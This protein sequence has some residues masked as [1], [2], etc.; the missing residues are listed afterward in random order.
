MGPARVTYAGPIELLFL[1]TGNICRS[2]MG[3]AILAERLSRR[4]VDASVGSAGLVLQGDPADP[5]AVD[6]LGRMGIDL[7]DHR[8]RIGTSEVV[9]GADLRIA[10]ENRHVRSA[11]ASGARFDRTFTLPDLVRRAEA[12]GPRRPGESLDAWLD[13]LGEGRT[14]TSVMRAN[15]ADEVVDP[16]GGSRRTFRR[17]AD[18]LAD[19]I[20]RLV[21]L[22]WP[23]SATDRLEPTA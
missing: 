13:R 9:A 17:C 22:A 10:M 23:A 20:D 8:S 2:P 7:A 21:A 18:E 3:A 11:V 12:A 1:C 6:A 15:P 5:H 4:G 16:V 14:P 19:L